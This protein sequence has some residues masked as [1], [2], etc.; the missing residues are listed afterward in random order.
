MSIANC[1]REIECLLCS[2]LVVECEPRYRR[3]PCEQDYRAVSPK[4]REFQ[5]G[6]LFLPVNY[7]L[8]ERVASFYQCLLLIKSVV[9]A[10][11][12]ESGIRVD[13]CTRVAYNWV[14]LNR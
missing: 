4:K 12:Y 2:K 7:P 10:V 3:D 13:W 8:S 14:T 5:R 6:P 1:Q 11:I 9:V